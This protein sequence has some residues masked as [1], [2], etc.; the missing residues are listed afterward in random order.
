MT[1]YSEVTGYIPTN[2]TIV[3]RPKIELMVNGK[4]YSNVR[5]A[6]IVD[7]TNEKTLESA[8]SWSKGRYWEKQ[9]EEPTVETFPNNSIYGVQ[10]HDLE[11]RGE[12]GRAYKVL[13]TTPTTGFYYVDMR[14]DSCNFYRK[15]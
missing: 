12:G 1:N 5:P 13:V 9:T 11:I 7:S 3:S 6:Y 4:N 14:E 2:I 10:I 8:M 15:L